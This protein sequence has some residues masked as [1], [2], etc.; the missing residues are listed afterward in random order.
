MRERPAG[1]GRYPALSPHG[2]WSISQVVKH[3]HQENALSVPCERSQFSDSTEHSRLRLPG[4]VSMDGYSR[5]AAHAWGRHGD[6]RPCRIVMTRRFRCLAAYFN[7][8]R[9]SETCRGGLTFF[10]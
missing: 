1:Y 4:L 2:G 3:D 10:L 9:F 7:A 5:W 6:A 8:N